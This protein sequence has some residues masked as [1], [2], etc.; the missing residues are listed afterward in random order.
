MPDSK[1]DSGIFFRDQAL[2]LI[3]AG[4]NVDMVF[5]EHRSLRTFSFPKFCRNHFQIAEEIECGILTLR[6]RA[7]SPKLS[8]VLGGRLW[9]K[10]TANLV[11]IYMLRHGSPDLIHVHNALWAGRAA[12]I[13]K[14]R[15]GIPYMLTE[16]SSLILNGP[17]KSATPYVSEAYRE[18][19]VLAAVSKPLA[20]SMRRYQFNN[21]I[22]I[23][24]NLVNTS[25]FTL[26]KAE[27]ADSPF[28]VLSV[29][30]LTENKSHEFLMKAFARAFRQQN[31]AR[32]VIIGDGPCRTRLLHAAKQLGI[33]QQTL[34][35][36][37]QK[38]EEVRRAMWKAHVLVL[39]SRYETFGIV[40]IEAMA[41]GLPT[42][43]T[44]SGGPESV[45]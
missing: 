4:V 40:L 11:E 33:S 36:G 7:W 9:A 41:T 14:K 20:L 2:A 32:L 45:L 34:F 8:S 18:A 23:I 43:A 26:P 17:A 22:A 13:I 10:W 39:S 25:F 42:I 31:N 16:H 35:L 30:K 19:T 38:R 28:V 6:R 1:P 15:H 12:A 27:P 21:S 44:R 5:V 37:H 3:K 24:P 29:G